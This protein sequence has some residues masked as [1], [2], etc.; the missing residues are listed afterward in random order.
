MHAWEDSLEAQGTTFALSCLA[1]CTLSSP[2]STA[3]GLFANITLHSSPAAKGTGHPKACWFHHILW[4]QT[5]WPI[6]HIDCFAYMKIK[7]WTQKV[8]NEIIF[9]FMPSQLFCHISLGM[10]FLGLAVGGLA[11][12]VS[13]IYSVLWVLSNF[14][15]FSWLDILHS[16]SPWFTANGVL[17]AGRE[18]R[19]KAK[20]SEGDMLSLL[21]S[22]FHSLLSW[23]TC[24]AGCLCV[25]T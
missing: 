10:Q 15:L 22:V 21:F 9:F 18:G 14:S 7:D 20:W 8:T 2:C 19:Q 25:L 16:V 17:K 11:I 24:L 1:G 5:A 12:Q 23:Y 6:K 13:H 4:Q 3:H